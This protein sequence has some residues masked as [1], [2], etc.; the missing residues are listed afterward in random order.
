MVLAGNTEVG[1][2]LRETVSRIHTRCSAHREQLENALSAGATKMTI[3]LI[4]PHTLGACG[5]PKAH[6]PC[7]AI[8]TDTFI[9]L[10]HALTVG[11]AGK[12]TAAP[13]DGTV[14]VLNN[15][16]L[17][18]YVFQAALGEHTQC[19]IYTVERSGGSLRM[20]VARTGSLQ[21]NFWADRSSAPGQKYIAR[22]I[23]DVNA[24]GKGGDLEFS[25]GTPCNY[26][27]RAAMMETY[28]P[29]C[30]SSAT[31]KENEQRLLAPMKDLLRQLGKGD[32]QAT[33][34]VYHA[35]EL[36][37]G[38]R[39]QYRLPYELTPQECG[40][41]LRVRDKQTNTLLDV[42]ES[43][44]AAYCVNDR[45]LPTSDGVG[46]AKASGL[47]PPPLPE[48]YVQGQRV[49]F[50]SHPWARLLNHADA[51]PGDIEQVYL[52]AGS[53]FSLPIAAVRACRLPEEYEPEDTQKMQYK[54]FAM[55][56]AGIDGA[57]FVMHGSKVINDKPEA[58]FSG[59]SFA[60]LTSQ[61]FAF[62]ISSIS[63]TGSGGNL[64]RN[65]AMLEG[66]LT[67]GDET[68]KE[69]I[70]PALSYSAFSRWSKNR[71]FDALGLGTLAV[72]HLDPTLFVLD[73]SKTRVSLAACGGLPAK[74]SLAQM[75]SAIR[76][77][78]ALWCLGVT[79]PPPEP[80]EA[81]KDEAKKNEASTGAPAATQSNKAL[82]TRLDG[83]YFQGEGAS[84]EGR[85][86]KKP[87][88][89][90]AAGPASSRQPAVSTA[91]IVPTGTPLAKKR[92][93]P[94]PASAAAVKAF[95]QGYD[96][97]ETSDGDKA[98]LKAALALLR[99]MSKFYTQG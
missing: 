12:Y 54:N 96:K 4:D 82:E 39:E 46:G 47:A 37:H 25:W 76:I 88:E 15:F 6:Y 73:G 69:S 9:D 1:S 14:G 31:A 63:S 43:L 38:G 77:K 62:L 24:V 84:D 90:F 21:D 53:G 50:S 11:H 72:V 40:Q 3:E 35:A 13:S 30:H 56:Q 74:V 26:T 42:A 51:E 55:H 81:Q 32:G 65:Y 58:L 70:P 85:R 93:P 61:T 33:I 52:P 27:A 87:A 41:L 94:G 92:K 75:L 17:G 19:M 99:K 28:S 67:A 45:G 48:L 29:W 71:L 64:N 20:S 57:Y 16:G 83:R 98:K 95:R 60:E 86:N 7:L 5:K 49:D 36:P 2:Q 68:L 91:L 10:E 34:F 44:A 23:A 79:K 59:A 80:D 78:L 18:L 97:V 22:V 66:Y 89:Q 8:G